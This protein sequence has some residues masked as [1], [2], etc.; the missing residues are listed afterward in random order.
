MAEQVGKMM[1]HVSR[2]MA[3]KIAFARLLGGDSTYDEAVAI[4][5]EGTDS[6]DRIMKRRS[7]DDVSFA[8]MLVNGVENH[9]TEID[10]IIND[11]LKD[12]K[13]TT[14][15][16]VEL[17]ILRIAVYELTYTPDVPQGAVIN[18]AVELAKMYC[19]DNKYAY[20]NG[21]LS[22]YVKFLNNKE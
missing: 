13:T 12:W 4:S 15:P 19:D 10:E 21:V 16:K 9:T 11:Y 8:R 5:Y 18:E 14:L 3:M 1:R 22:T 20:I 6:Y 2:E 17:T 7:D